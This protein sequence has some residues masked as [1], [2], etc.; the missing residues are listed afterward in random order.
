[1]GKNQ[2]KI[3]FCLLTDDSIYDN[4]YDCNCPVID[5]IKLLQDLT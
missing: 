1:M 3:A 4:P 5:F 2:N